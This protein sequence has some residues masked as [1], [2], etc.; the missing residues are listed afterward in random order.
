MRR[1]QFERPS[2]CEVIE[3]QQKRLVENV[4][5][6]GRGCGQTVD[7]RPEI[8]VGA[9]R[10]SFETGVEGWKWHTPIIG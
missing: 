5:A 1:H 6:L 8:G 2:G 10:R 9:D 4:L 7:I 3:R